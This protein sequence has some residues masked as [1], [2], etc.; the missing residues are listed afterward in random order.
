MKYNNCKPTNG[1]DVEICIPRHTGIICKK[2]ESLS[3][4][5]RWA[6]HVALMGDGRRIHTIL[7]GKSEGTRPCGR[8]KIRWEDNMI[9][10]LKEVDYEVIGRHFPRIQ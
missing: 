9:R 7:L 4:I 3:N 8:P 6:G 5:L 1:T 10:D 2:D